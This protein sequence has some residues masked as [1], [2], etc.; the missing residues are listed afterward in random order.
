M[1]YKRFYNEAVQMHALGLLDEYP[2]KIGTPSI[3][4]SNECMGGMPNKV[5]MVDVPAQCNGLN[6]KDQRGSTNPY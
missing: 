1:D 3:S 4:F 6:R 2:T 5:H